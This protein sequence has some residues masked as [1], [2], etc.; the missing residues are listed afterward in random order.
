VGAC[1]LSPHGSL[2]AQLQQPATISCRLPCLVLCRRCSQL[3]QS[4]AARSG[5]AFVLR[6]RSNLCG[7][8][9]RKQLIA[10]SEGTRCVLH[11]GTVRFSSVD[12]HGAVLVVAE[13]SRSSWL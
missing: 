3:Q 8:I 1:C 5:I 2:L 6:T 12:S 11:Y 10:G 7:L 13:F 9:I 4:K